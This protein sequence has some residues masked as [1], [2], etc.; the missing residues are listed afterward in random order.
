M[1]NRGRRASSYTRA[2]ESFLFA[3]FFVSSSALLALVAAG[4]RSLAVYLLVVY[5]LSVAVSELRLPTRTASE[6]E[7]R[8]WR[9][10]Q[11]AG[12][13]VALVL[14]R[15]VALLVQESGVLG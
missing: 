9:V 4:V 3:Q 5:V 6:W 14:A 8:V 11:G 2:Q 13:V 10:I 1:Q 12:I 15:E 7:Q